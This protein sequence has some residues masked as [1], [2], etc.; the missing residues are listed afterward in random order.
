MEKLQDIVNQYIL[1]EISQVDIGQQRC[2]DMATW[3][4]N[5]Q[6]NFTCASAFH[7]L[8]QKKE[9]TPMM[10]KV[11][12]KE[13]PFKISFNI[14]RTIYKKLSFADTLQRLYVAL[15]PTCVCCRAPKI[16]SLNHVFTISDMASSVWSYISPAL[17]FKTRGRNILSILNHWWS[18]PTKNHAPKFLLQITPMIV[19][20]E[21]WKA[22]CGKKYG[23]KSISTYNICQQVLLQVKISMRLKFSKMGWD[24]N[25]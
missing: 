17:G 25:W 10:S 24:W 15:L 11:W 4:P 14:W 8:R 3:T 21:L 12:I 20:W 5:V 23:T 7:L 19:L 1:S 2:K 13:L 6:G 22:I 18:I 9:P 16:E